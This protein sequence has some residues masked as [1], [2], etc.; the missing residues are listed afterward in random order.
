M[1]SN[2]FLA[3]SG[4]KNYKDVL[5]RKTAVPSA[6][7]VIDISNDAGKAQLKARDDNESAYHNLILANSNKVA[8]NLIKKSVTTDL[9]DSSSPM[10]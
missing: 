3:M 9:P 8:F 5:T 2:Q 4:K 6:M 1:W 10:A 7:T